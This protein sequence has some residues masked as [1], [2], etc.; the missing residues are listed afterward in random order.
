M[1]VNYKV[2]VCVCAHGLPLE[3]MA[4]GLI[5]ATVF[6]LGKKYWIS[7]SA[8]SSVAEPCSG[9][10]ES[11]STENIDLRLWRRLSSHV[12]GSVIF[13]LIPHHDVGRLVHGVYGMYVVCESQDHVYITVE[14]VVCVLIAGLMGISIWVALPASK[15]SYCILNKVNEWVRIC[16]SII[17]LYQSGCCSFATGISVGPSMSLHPLTAS[18][19]ARHRASIGPL[20]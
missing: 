16:D 19:L 14:E 17:I 8:S 7:F 3:S 13:G 9:L 10:W 5:T 12:I 2:C 1:S 4:L 18:S 20:Q 6:S 11:S 15:S